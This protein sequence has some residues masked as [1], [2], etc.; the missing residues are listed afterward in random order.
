MTEAYQ[1]SSMPGYSLP[2]YEYR[3]PAELESGVS[4]IYPVIVVGAGLAGLTAALELGSRG[5]RAVV[6]DD[7]N[8]LGASGLSSR[9]IC[10]AKRSIEIFER[11]G[12][13]ARIR[14][15]GVTWNEGEVYRGAE[16]MY[17]FNLQPETDQKFPAFVNL[18]QFYV[19]QFL[20]EKIQSVAEADLRW[21]NRVVSLK[22]EPDRVL[23]GVET[24]D[25]LYEIRGRYVIAADGGHSALR[26]LVGA[27]DGER[28]FYEDRWCIADVKMDTREEP[29][30]KA[31]PDG[32]LTQ[33]GAIWYHQMADGIWRTDWQ[34]GHLPDADAEPQYKN[35]EK[36][37][38]DPPEM[39]SAPFQSAPP[40]TC[41]PWARQR[42]MPPE[43]LATLSKPALPSVCVA[44]A[45]RAPERHTTTIGFS[46]PSLSCS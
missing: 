38:S 30:R 27:E 37:G 21:K 12:V 5:V 18:Q 20:V 8:T 2:V 36:S 16:C 41:K 3:R 44:C 33:G 34:I 39:G 42:S 19:E 15:K 24:P 4:T 14:S 46:F 43:R 31:Y 9:G 40:S 6:L 35:Q 45:E 28:S 29:V 23:L 22:E 13:A 11:F 26:E 25:G 10:Y 17:R 1:P 32:I 7:D